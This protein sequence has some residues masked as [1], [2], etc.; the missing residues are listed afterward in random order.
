MAGTSYR[1][2]ALVLKKTKL[3]ESDLVLTFLKDDG[4]RLSAVAKGARKPANPFATRLDLFAVDDLLLATGRNLDVVCEARLTSSFR[5]ISTQVDRYA[6][7]SPVL[8]ALSRTTHEDLGIPRLFDMSVSALSMMES[9]SVEQAPAITAAFLLKLFA[10]LGLKPNL[11]ECV[12]CGR[13]VDPAAVSG[14]V[15]FS[16]LEGGLL[17]SVCA[18]AHQTIRLPAVTVSWMHALMMSPFDAVAGMNVDLSVSFAVL[19][20]CH[21]WLRENMGTN[22]RSLNY[23]LSCGLF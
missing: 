3:G 4:S 16:Y 23:L 21:S 14:D 5:G 18:P 12:S 13:A 11:T 9:V 19:Q 22:L 2:R 1:C 10:M 20:V 7:A 8:E 17:C 15:P 6:A